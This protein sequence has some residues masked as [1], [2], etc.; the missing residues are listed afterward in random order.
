MVVKIKYL[1]EANKGLTVKV[2][3][4][5]KTSTNAAAKQVADLLIK[6][7]G[8]EKQVTALKSERLVRGITQTVLLSPVLQK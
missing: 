8:L 4:N 7:T 1:E 2:S 3:S 5:L 6:L